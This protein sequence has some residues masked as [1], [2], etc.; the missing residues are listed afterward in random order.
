MTQTIE[1]VFDGAVLRPD[2]PLSLAPN[3]RVRINILD[4][5]I[6][7][8]PTKAQLEAEYAEMAADTEAEAEALEWIEG[9]I[10]DVADDSE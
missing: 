9:V 8:R 2:L 6:P 7:A 10:G 5:D 1:A 4:G 3:T